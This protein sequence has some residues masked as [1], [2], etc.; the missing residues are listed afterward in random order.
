MFATQ[1]T[2]IALQLIAAFVMENSQAYN[3]GDVELSFPGGRNNI[4]CVLPEFGCQ[5]ETN[6]PDWV[7]TFEDGSI[8]VTTNIGEFSFCGHKAGG[9]SDEWLEIVE[10]PD[11]PNA[12]YLKDGEVE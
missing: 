11:N 8:I 7:K 4:V 5:K 2:Q 9:C 3:T 1:F 10:F 6:N 12:N